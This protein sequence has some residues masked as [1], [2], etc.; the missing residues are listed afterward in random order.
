MTEKGKNNCTTLLNG[1]Q[2]NV[3]KREGVKRTH[4]ISKR[5]SSNV[6]TREEIPSSAVKELG[7][8]VR[9]GQKGT[10]MSYGR[11]GLRAPE[12]HQGKRE[13]ESVQGL[14]KCIQYLAG[15]HLRGEEG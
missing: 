4:W 10:R 8:G 14:Q 11:K 7:T 5:V 12:L 9:H 3:V 6:N 13:T 1:E 15:R 2:Q